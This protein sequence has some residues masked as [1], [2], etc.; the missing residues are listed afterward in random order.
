MSLELSKEDHTI[1]SK[2]SPIHEF[3]EISHHWNLISLVP[4]HFIDIN[5]LATLSFIIHDNIVFYLIETHKGGIGLKMHDAFMK[6]N[7]KGPMD[8]KFQAF[9]CLFSASNLEN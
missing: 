9:M 8:F 1:N 5:N 6:M 4:F 2:K 3:F 7:F